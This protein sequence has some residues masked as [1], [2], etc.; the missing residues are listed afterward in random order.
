MTE[1][2]REES[3]ELNEYLK[4]VLTQEVSTNGYVKSEMI[5]NTTPIVKYCGVCRLPKTKCKC[6]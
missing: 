6:R 2:I 3:E 1:I 5:V 4:S